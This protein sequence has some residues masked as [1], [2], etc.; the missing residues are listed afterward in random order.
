MCVTVYHKVIMAAVGERIGDMLFMHQ[1]Y[2]SA[3]QLKDEGLGKDP[4]PGHFLEEEF[5][6]IVVAEDAG[7]AAGEILQYA[8]RERRR[9]IARVDHVFDSSFVEKIDRFFDLRHV[10]V[11]V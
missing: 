2:F 8:E 4:S 11:G 10:I 5:V 7:Y 3:S 6:P 9:K 1:D